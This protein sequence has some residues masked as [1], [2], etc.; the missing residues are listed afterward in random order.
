MVRKKSFRFN[1]QQDFLTLLWKVINKGTHIQPDFLL[2]WPLWNSLSVCFINSVVVITALLA[3]IL[4]WWKL[5]HQK[6]L[7]RPVEF[8]NLWSVD[9]KLN[10]FKY[11]EDWK[12]WDDNRSLAIFW[13]TPVRYMTWKYNTQKYPTLFM[14][15]FE[16]ILTILSDLFLKM[17]WVNYNET[18]RTYHYQLFRK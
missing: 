10:T 8:Q 6:F 4:Q 1:W 18:M 7:N 14:K 16:M 9:T 13:C 5:F 17:K 15:Y 2:D 11:S 3:T 12:S